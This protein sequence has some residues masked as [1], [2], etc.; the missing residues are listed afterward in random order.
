MHHS[1]RSGKPLILHATVTGAE[2][3]DRGEHTG[4]Q[5]GSK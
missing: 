2:L 4:P 5:P 1:D 3:P